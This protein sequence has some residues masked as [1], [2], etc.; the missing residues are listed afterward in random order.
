MA[1]D[2]RGTGDITENK[3]RMLATTG[4]PYVPS[5]LACPDLILPADDGVLRML[6]D[7]GTL[8]CEANQGCSLSNFTMMPLN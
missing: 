8:F 1:I 2:P 7:S 3:T 5:P 6:G 4:G